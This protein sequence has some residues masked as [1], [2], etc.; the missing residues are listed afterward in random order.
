MIYTHIVNSVVVRETELL[1]YLIEEN[2]E[3]NEFKFFCHGAIR[4]RLVH[5][6]IRDRLVHGAI[7]DRLVHGAMRDRFV[8][9][10]TFR[11]EINKESS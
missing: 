7:R 2:T 6:A 10:L 9:V 8:I 11:W 5:G 1:I 3:N 4:D